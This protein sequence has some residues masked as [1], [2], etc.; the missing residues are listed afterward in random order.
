MP[1]STRN[2]I[3]EGM[4]FFYAGLLAGLIGT[5]MAAPYIWDTLHHK[6]RPQRASW[7]IWTVLG[8]IAIFSQL[9]K[10]ATDSVW[11]TVGQTIGTTVIFLLSLWLGTGGFSRRDIVSLGLAAMGLIMWFAT[12]EAAYALFITMAVDAI[13]AVLTAL[14]AYEMP[15]SE[16][17][18]MWLLSVCTGVLGAIA[19]G[20]FD[21]ILMAYPLY[22]IAA[23]LCVITGIILGNRRSAQDRL[24][25]VQ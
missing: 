5:V 25:V 24:A 20:R 10:G 8:Y 17:L 15:G 11:M 16:T 21:P 4:F 3:V 18:L 6:T 9:A 23:N 19:V 2:A 7:L 12:R 13:G 14:K 22:V 1:K